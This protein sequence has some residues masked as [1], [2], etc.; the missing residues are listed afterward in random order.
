MPDDRATYPAVSA[1]YDGVCPTCRSKPP[2]ALT[3]P[4]CGHDCE[5]KHRSAESVLFDERGR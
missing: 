3:Y 4:W 5:Q 2:Q 1:I